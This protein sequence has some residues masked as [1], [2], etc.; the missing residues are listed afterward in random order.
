MMS[1]YL[2][3]E[4]FDHV[5]QG[6][7]FRMRMHSPLAEQDFV[8]TADPQTARI[9]FQRVSEQTRPFR[10]R[11]YAVYVVGVLFVD[12][13][14][15][16]DPNLL[17]RYYP[18]LIRSLSNILVVVAGAPDRPDLYITT[19]ERGIFPVLSETQ[20]AQAQG[21]EYY[22]EL[23]FRLGPLMRSHL[24][25]NNQFMPDLPETLW[26]GTAETTALSE[27]GAVLE[28]WDLLPTPFPIDQLL[29]PEDF[30]HLKR[31]F[32]IGGLSYGNLSV[33]HDDG[34]FWMSASGVNK[35]RMRDIGRDILLVTDYDVK[36]EGMVLSVPAHVTP[37]R[38]SVDAIEHWKIYRAHSEVGAIIHLHAWME[39]VP[40]TDINYPCGSIELADAVSSH[41]DQAPD[42]ARWVVG[43]K[44]HGLTITGRSLDD[45]LHRVDG[46]VLRQVPMQ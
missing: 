28:Q 30:Q 5:A 40:A 3:V 32:G 21:S 22:R 9:V 4:G 17:A 2:W 10:R 16:D 24:I 38:A 39:G 15:P 34:S 46:Q 20:R 43:L 25:I 42:P 19:L 29:S 35:A 8:E 1:Q 36:R 45:I 37:R 7:E 26:Q 13:I 23:V 12:A 6:L 18:Y 44:N 11:T 41:V 33:R 31:L 14:D 27:A